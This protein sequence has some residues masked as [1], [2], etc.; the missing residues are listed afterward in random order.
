VLMGRY[1]FYA[2]RVQAMR[3]YRTRLISPAQSS[4]KTLTLLTRGPAMLPHSLLPPKTRACSLALEYLWVSAIFTGVTGCVVGST[5]VRLTPGAMHVQ[6]D[7]P[8]PPE[9]WV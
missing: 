1:G 2:M 9:S 4:T 3:P 6:S 8:H 7:V 5:E